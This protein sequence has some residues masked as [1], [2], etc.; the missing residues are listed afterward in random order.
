MQDPLGGGRWR[1]II[2]GIAV[3]VVVTDFGDGIHDVLVPPRCP[4]SQRIHVDHPVK[5]S[6]GTK[7]NAEACDI[8]VLVL[9]CD[10]QHAA[11]PTAI[12]VGIEDDASL[13]ALQDELELIAVLADTLWQ[14][15]D[16]HEGAV[17]TM[18]KVELAFSRDIVVA[19][20]SGAAV[21]A[22][23][24][25][26][27][28]PRSRLSEARAPRSPE[29]GDRPRLAKSP[30]GTT[31]RRRG[32]GSP[33]DHRRGTSPTAVERRKDHAQHPRRSWQPCPRVQCHPEPRRRPSGSGARR[34]SAAGGSWRS[35]R[36]PPSKTRKQARA[37]T[38]V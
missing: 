4:A 27:P 14:Q 18:A 1:F 30:R 23:L 21:H 20:H 32:A 36:C 19:R 38:G 25:K 8:V 24:A 11:L 35:S 2:V 33:W 7:G 12:V 5:P 28:C 22:V 9:D 37:E 6:A 10:R 26:K 34:S 15:S 16:G 13:S 3:V 17:L 29:R 31:T